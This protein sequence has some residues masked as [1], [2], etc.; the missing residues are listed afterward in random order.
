MEKAEQ[1]AE[2]AGYE[3]LAEWQDLLEE[4]FEECAGDDVINPIASNIAIR[5][6]EHNQKRGWVVEVFDPDQPL[7][8]LPG[9]GVATK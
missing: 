1:E 3:E 5:Y 9:G 8:V 7:V 4:A 2:K 6:N